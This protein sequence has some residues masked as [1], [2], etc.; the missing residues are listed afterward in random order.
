[1]SKIAIVTDSTA[2][3]PEELVQKHNLTITPLVVIWDGETFEDGIDIQPSQFYTRLKT[4]KVMPS[5]S[6][7]TPAAMIAAFESLIAKDYEVLGIFISNKL[8]GTIASAI[9]AKDLMEKGADKVTIFD[10]E[11]TAMAMGFQVLAV[12]NAIADG[13]NLDDALALA[14]KA[15]K[16]SGVF[17]AVDTLEFLHRGGRIGGAQRFLGTALNMKPVLTIQD[18]SIAAVE[19]VRTKTKVH[20]RVLELVAEQV[21][22][23]DNIRIA[24][25]S[26]NAEPDAK[27]LLESATQQLD[28]AEAIFTEISPVLGTHTGPGTVGLAYIAGI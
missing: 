6:Q 8:S 16:N 9:Q 23:K 24:T 18:G 1:M 3:L 21:Q 11:S 7:A 4:A 15:R 12:A 22:G 14:E 2:Y 10:S 27:A 28:P 5:T 26:A 20:N 13:A 17:F 19:R 25:L